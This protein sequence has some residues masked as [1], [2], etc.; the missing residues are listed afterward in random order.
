[1]F[2]IEESIGFHIIFVNFHLPLKRKRHICL[3]SGN[4]LKLAR[5][6]GRCLKEIISCPD[7]S[8]SINMEG[9]IW[10]DIDINIFIRYQHYRICKYGCIFIILLVLF[11]SIHIL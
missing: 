2:F 3:R 5:E 10:F 4:L 6:F 9:K 11:I 7:I 8:V 1:M